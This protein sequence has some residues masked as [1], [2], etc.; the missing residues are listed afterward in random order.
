MAEAAKWRHL[1]SKLLGG[2]R[3]QHNSKHSGRLGLI[4]AY[5]MSAELHDM[6]MRQAACFNF[7]GGPGVWTSSQ[8]LQ[9]GS[10]Y[11]RHHIE[12]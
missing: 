8:E 4:P 6:T 3:G 5:S 10:H 1:S 12:G 2:Q 9:A 11:N 7:K